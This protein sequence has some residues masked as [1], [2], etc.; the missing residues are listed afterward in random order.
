MRKGNGWLVVC[1]AGR[2]GRAVLKIDLPEVVVGA[3]ISPLG[4]CA[5]EAAVLGA[6]STVLGS[7]GFI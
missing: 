5:L 4:S 3:T 1:L 6:A 2:L 7:R